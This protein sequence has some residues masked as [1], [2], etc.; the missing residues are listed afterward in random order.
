MTSQDGRLDDILQKLAELEPTINTLQKLQESGI[1]SI[2]DAI[3]EQSDNLFNYASTM[4]LLGA[5]SAAMKILP[6]LS[7]IAGM[8]DTDDLQEKLEHI[9]WKALINLFT[10]FLDFVGSDLMSIEPPEG[11]GKTLK[12]LSEVR[13]P[14]MEYLIRIVRALSTRMMKELKEQRKM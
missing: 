12:L 10:A 2:L 1:M 14:E 5:A 6:V 8:V 7:Q 3:A 9:P 13:S 11:K 4:E